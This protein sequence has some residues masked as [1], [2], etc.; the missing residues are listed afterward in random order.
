MA[1]ITWET[2]VRYFRFYCG[3]A[4]VDIRCESAEAAKSLHYQRLLTLHDGKQT[5]VCFPLLNEPE[6][7]TRYYEPEMAART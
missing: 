2:E 4:Y 7:V 5:F 3:S 1:G 6:D